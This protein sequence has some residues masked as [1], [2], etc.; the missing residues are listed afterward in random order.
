L[1]E[2]VE[3]VAEVK[4]FETMIQNPGRHRINIAA[5]AAHTNNSC[6]KFESPDFFNSFSHKRTSAT[7]EKQPQFDV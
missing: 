5:S 3:E 4:I 7:L 2:A 1:A 6:T